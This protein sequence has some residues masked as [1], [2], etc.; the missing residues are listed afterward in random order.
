MS[1]FLALFLSEKN[2]ESFYQNPKLFDIFL[3]PSIILICKYL[4]Y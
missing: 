3:Y 4:I 2:S 1:I